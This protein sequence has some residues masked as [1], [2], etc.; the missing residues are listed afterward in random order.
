MPQI[1]VFE[2]WTRVIIVKGE[3][4]DDR[5]QIKLEQTLEFDVHSYRDSPEIFKAIRG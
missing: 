1:T 5:V 3:K 4:N 2:N